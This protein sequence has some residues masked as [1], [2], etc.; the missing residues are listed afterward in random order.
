MA[1][2]ELRGEEA[3]NAFFD[4]KDAFNQD[5][6][7]SDNPHTEGT[8]EYTS[9]LHGWRS[10]RDLAN[11]RKAQRVKHGRK[12]KKEYVAEGGY[13]STNGVVRVRQTVDG[14]AI[15]YSLAPYLHLVN[16]SPT[17][18]AWGYGGSGPAQLA[19]AILADYLGDNDRAVALHQRFKFAVV[20]RLNGSRGFI[21]QDL[22]IEDW[23]K[24][25]SRADVKKSIPVRS[26]RDEWVLD[27][28]DYYTVSVF[29]G[30]G[31]YDTTEEI[32]DLKEAREL[33]EKKVR[34]Y[35]R[36]CM[37]YAIRQTAQTLVENMYP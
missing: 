29:L 18:F 30:R 17:G 36:A 3:K 32:G 33:A 7:R 4:G 22:E 19:L 2:N 14:E 20:S 16:H 12:P 24:Q 34:Q 5:R 25:I 10:A 9:W 26:P 6:P 28:P 23:L 11:R 13:D 31:K 8:F 37:I 27:Q 21:V 15:E 35:D 1:N